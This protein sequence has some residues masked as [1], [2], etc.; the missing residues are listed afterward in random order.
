M[1]EAYRRL[2]R[3]IPAEGEHNRLAVADRQN[4]VAV[5][6]TGC[7]RV[8]IQGEERRLGACRDPEGKDSRVEVV[9]KGRSKDFRRNIERRQQD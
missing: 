6:R 4:R 9:D 3:D 2:A 8:E 5:A 7:N 1:G